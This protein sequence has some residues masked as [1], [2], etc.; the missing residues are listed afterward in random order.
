MGFY[1]DFETKPKRQKSNMASWI[2]VAVVSALIGSGTTAALVP[3]LIKSNVIEVNSGSTG[4]DNVVQAAEQINVNVQS[5]V[6]E[7]VNKI[8]PAV[9]GVLNLQKTQ[10]F[11][12]RTSAEQT[13]GTGSG[14]IYDKE[15]YIIT[16]NHVVEGADNVE[17][18]MPDGEHVK[19]KVI[20]TDPLTDLA[21]IKVEADDVKD[22]TPA[23]FGNSDSLN[24]GEPAI[25]IGNPLGL[26]FAQSVT[27][28][29]IS[30]T[31]REMPIEDPQTG[32]TVFTETV[33]QTDAA[34]NPGNSGGALVNI[35]GELVGINS[36]KIATTGVEGIGFAIP[37]NEAQPIVKQLMDSGK[38]ERPAIGIGGVSLQGLSMRERPEVPVEEGIVIAE[39]QENAKNAGLQKLDVITKIDDQ[40]VTDLI[41]LRKVLFKKKPGDKVTVE[42]YREKEVK[43]VEV[44]LTKLSGE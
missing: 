11:F 2:A 31:K 20:G 36:A 5:G 10:D 26:K 18:A 35:K 40:K 13:A 3:T 14:V 16:N 32:Q 15:G 30:A 8:K 23:V 39:V 38:V 33:L 44:T 34:I 37:I 24:I 42:F 19:A 25:A 6:V 4:G 1:D 17:V 28:G 22:I 27:V 43:T 21:V 7:A 41:D 9:V 12:G 29:V